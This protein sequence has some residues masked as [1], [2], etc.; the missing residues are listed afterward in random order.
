[1]WK[2]FEGIM[3]PRRVIERLRRRN[4]YYEVVI[5]DLRDM[6]ATA[7]AE[8]EGLRRLIAD[9]IREDGNTLLKGHLSELQGRVAALN[10]EVFK[11]RKDNF[12][13]QVKLTGAL[14]QLKS[15][16]ENSSSTNKTWPD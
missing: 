13:L 4:G 9:T 5:K 11:L 15:H 12:A 1:M 8:I 6:L 7:N 16:K 3:R 10:Y 2:W 14:A